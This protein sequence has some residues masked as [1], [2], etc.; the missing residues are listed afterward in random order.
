MEIEG[1]ETTWLKEDWDILIF[2]DG[3]R[4]DTF[5]NEYQKYL[6]CNGNLKM[7]KTYC[8]GTTKWMKDTFIGKDCSNI[9]Y[10]NPMYSFDSFVPNHNFYKVISVWDSD[11]N[12]DYDTVM[13]EAIT[14]RALQWIKKYPNKKYIV[15]YVQ[16]CRPYIHPM[17]KNIDQILKPGNKKSDRARIIRTLLEN[18]G[19]AKIIPNTVFWKVGAFFGYPIAKGEAYIK[20]GREGII[21]AYTY[22]LREALKEVNKIIEH[23]KNKKII[24][25]SDHGELLGEGGRYGHGGL[26]NDLIMKVPWLEIQ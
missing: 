12:K 5:K 13:P 25:T 11:W 3:C 2:L 24:I 9:I 23:Q 14:K 6:N 8:S 22:S 18:T 21:E 10:V 4:Y 1:R 20:Y 15:Q 7:A 26:V 19:L 16:P 17:F